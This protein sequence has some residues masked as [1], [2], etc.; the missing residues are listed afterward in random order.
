MIKEHIDNE[1]PQDERKEIVKHEGETYF[2]RAVEECDGV[3]GRFRGMTKTMV[4]GASPS[5]IPRQPP[6]S[7]YAENPIP[8]YD[9]PL[10]YK[11]DDV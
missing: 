4:T 8:Q 3:G 2:S 6:G 11:I 1:T 9:D 7:P 5:A 10:N